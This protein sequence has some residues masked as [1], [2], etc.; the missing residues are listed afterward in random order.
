MRDIIESVKILDYALMPKVI[1]NRQCAF[2]YR[3]SRFKKRKEYI[4][5][6]TFRLKKGDPKEILAEMKFYREGRNAKH[7]HDPSAGS[8]FKNPSPKK[9][10]GMLLD[11]LGLKGF[12]VGDACI[13]EKHA[14]F[15]IN[16]GHATAT[17]IESLIQFIRETVFNQSGILLT[18]EIKILG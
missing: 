12:C 11:K 6:A 17:D 3:T 14:N 1:P 15:I 5:E 18:P 9:P 8:W 13:S 16:T 10:A 7:P 4:L 2:A